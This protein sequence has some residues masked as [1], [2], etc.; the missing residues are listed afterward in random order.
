VL[1]RL[2]VI[3]DRKRL[4]PGGLLRIEGQC[5]LIPKAKNGYSRDGRP[6]CRQGVLQEEGSVNVGICVKP[7]RIQRIRKLRRFP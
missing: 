6:D 7:P 3:E 2:I 1:A 5:E 4:A